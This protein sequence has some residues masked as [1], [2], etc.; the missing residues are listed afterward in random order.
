LKNLIEQISNPNN[1]IIVIQKYLDKQSSFCNIGFI[2]FYMRDDNFKKAFLQY[3]Y[4]NK[5]TIYNNVNNDINIEKGLIENN[6]TSN[7]ITT[8]IE[9]YSRK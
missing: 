8:D 3:E 5:I 4:K 1:E 6:L 7:I 2:E 9:I